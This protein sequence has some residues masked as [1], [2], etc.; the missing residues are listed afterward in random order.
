MSILLKINLA[1]GLNLFFYTN[2]SICILLA[3]YT[4]K[5]CFYE[6]SYHLKFKIIIGNKLYYLLKLLTVIQRCNLNSINLYYNIA[7]L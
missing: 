6:I 1:V 2:Y 4:K 7:R 3:F 5:N